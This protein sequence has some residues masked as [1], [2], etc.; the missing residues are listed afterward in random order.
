VLSPKVVKWACHVFS[1]IIHRTEYEGLENIQK[2]KLY[3]FA[4]NHVSASDPVMVMN[5]VDNLRI[6]AKAELFDVPVIRY[7]VKSAN[8]IPIKRDKKD[9]GGVIHAAKEI[10]NKKH[11][12]LI[13]PEGTRKAAN[14]N[15]KAKD[16]A[17]CIAQAA[18]VE[19]IPVYLCE[20]KGFLKKYKVK[21]GK[22]INVCE[23]LEEKE[24][25]AKD[26]KNIKEYTK[27]VMESIYS[28]RD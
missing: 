25:K 2:D 8:A 3:V 21:F 28:M 13:F 19:V 4:A 7:F 15:I 6:M 22:P 20:N 12:L 11:N 5:V 9:F 18:G 10:K 14:K 16:G 17:V 27:R 24:D 23:K 26:R 1:D